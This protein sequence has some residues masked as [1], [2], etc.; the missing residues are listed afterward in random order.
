M[1]GDKRR[2]ENKKLKE[3]DWMFE[4]GVKTSYQRKI[5]KLSKTLFGCMIGCTRLLKQ[6]NEKT[7][8]QMKKIVK[9]LYTRKLKEKF[10]DGKI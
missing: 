2:Y 7:N 8:G 9:L 3:D 5:F 6:I 10:F 1:P 4:K